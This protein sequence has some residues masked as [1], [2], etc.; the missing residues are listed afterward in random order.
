MEYSGYD[1]IGITFTTSPVGNAIYLGFKLADEEYPFNPVVWI[2]GSLA[3]TAAFLF[4][5]YFFY[6]KRRAEDVGT[7]FIFMS[8]YHVLM[9]LMLVCTISV[10]FINDDSDYFFPMLCFSAIVFAILE[11]IRNRGFRKIVSSFARFTVVFILAVGLNFTVSGTQGFGFETRV[12]SVSSV[13]S[14]TI[15]FNGLFSEYPEIYTNYYSGMTYTD[16]KAIET[17]IKFQKELIKRFKASGMKGLEYETYVAEQSG[18]EEQYPSKSTFYLNTTSGFIQIRYKTVTGNTIIRG[19][20]VTNKDL[21]MLAPLVNNAEF[22]KPFF[23]QAYYD[24]DTEDGNKDNDKTRLY[25]TTKIKNVQREYALTRTQMKSLQDAYVKDMQ[26][27]T[28]EEYFK[29]DIYCY[30]SGE[31]NIPVRTTFTNTIAVMAKFGIEV[32][33]LE[34]DV[35][36]YITANK[37]IDINAIEFGEFSSY[38]WDTW[39]N[40]AFAEVKTVNS[41]GS[42]TISNYS[43][44]TRSPDGIIYFDIYGTSYIIGNDGYLLKISETAAE[45]YRQSEKYY[46]GDYYYSIPPSVYDNPPSDNAGYDLATLYKE[47]Y[48]SDNA[49]LHEEM[50]VKLIQYKVADKTVFVNEIPTY[51][52][53]DNLPDNDLPTAKILSDQDLYSILLSA[54]PYYYSNQVEDEFI[55]CLDLRGRLYYVTDSAF[56]KSVFERS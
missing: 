8:I 6:R 16:D 27:M 31:G 22:A 35:E 39:G 3:T 42:F 45:E 43:V 5:A 48:I 50:Y 21:V 40:S 17:V 1:N 7:P 11:T 29:P 24:I 4:G 47:K 28:E 13:K 49:V 25:T 56:A 54:Q 44:E 55:Y 12:P 32:V 53:F 51:G 19:Y 15:N 18:Y 33:S 10:P 36:A 38:E 9:F 20:N 30:L 37:D 2:L 41:D 23:T 26:D 14:V 46:D 34:Q 52:S